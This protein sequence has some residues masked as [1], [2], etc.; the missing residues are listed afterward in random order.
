MVGG[1]VDHCLLIATDR[2]LI[3][4]DTGFGTQDVTDPARRLGPVRRVLGLRIDHDTTARAQVERLG[5]RAADVSDI[6]LTHLDLD[7]AGGLADFP[8]ARVHVHGPELRAA[9]TPRWTERPRYRPAQWAHGPRWVVNEA[10][11]SDTWLGLNAIR[12]LPGLGDDI[13]VVPLYGH[14]RGHVGVA[15]NTPAGWLLHAGD[16]FLTRRD[17]DVPLRRLAM[18]AYGDPGPRAAL[19][20]WHNTRA[21]A[22]LTGRDPR[23][24]V[25]SSHDRAM[26][27]AL[28]ARATGAGNRDM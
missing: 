12:E 18:T 23:L 3:L 7:H 25:F 1:L 19:A 28:R 9:Q 6:V 10:N 17:L 20:R 11:G 2:R 16:A 27:A 24:T 8:D 13:L 26:F 14:T 4:V 15:V 22:D 21:L 5:Y